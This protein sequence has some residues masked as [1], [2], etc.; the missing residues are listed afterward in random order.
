[1]AVD[2]LPYDDRDGLIWLDG[3]LVPWREAKLHILSHGLHYASAVFEGE[4]VYGGHVFRSRAHTDRLLNSARIMGME[5]PY[6]AERLEAAKR[7]VLG[8]C[9]LEDAYLRPIAWRGSEMMGVSAQDTTT[10]VAIAAWHWGAYFGDGSE[11][12]GIR[13]KTG[14]YR[15]PGPDCAPVD[16]KA[17]GLYMICTLNK[18]EV[19]AEGYHD[20]LMLDH[21]GFVAEGSG[22]NIFLIQDG[23]LHTP[24]PDTF[25]N[26]ITRQ[27]V[28][29][30]AGKRQI[31]VVERHIEP[32]EFERT[33]EVFVTG[34]AAEI[35]PVV[36][37]DGRRFEPGRITRALMEDF[38]AITT[39]G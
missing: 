12:A 8:A 22:A 21:R 36:E 26:G 32:A 7:E 23:E 33:T 5:I 15:R 3:G 30:L 31:P 4:R 20:A 39:T 35:T 37:I 27:A 16:A 9:G 29:E 2:L 17:A 10:H 14:R 13:M 19:E 34:T 24:T 28:I 38:R 18:H 6:T 25:L 1:M 11:M